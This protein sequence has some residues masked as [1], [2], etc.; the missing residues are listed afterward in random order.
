MC[1][2]EY[3]MQDFNNNVKIIDELSLL[4]AITNGIK[5]WTVTNQ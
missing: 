5:K 3:L 2:A 1:Q 4:T